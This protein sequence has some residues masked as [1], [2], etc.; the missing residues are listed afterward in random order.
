MDEQETLEYR[1]QLEARYG[2]VWN[3][4]ELARDFR[5]NAFSAPLVFVVRKSDG[6]KGRMEFNHSPRFYFNF[7]TGGGA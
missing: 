2:Q 6:I 4:D 1:K 3:T 5:V 7:T